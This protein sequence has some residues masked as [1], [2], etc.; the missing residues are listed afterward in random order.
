MS[1]FQVPGIELV[2]VH[3]G[4]EAVLESVPDMPDEGAMVE[5]PG[6]LLEEFV[7]QPDLQV[8]TGTVGVGQQL[9]QDT[10]PPTAGLH[11]LPGGDEQG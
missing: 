11:G 7:A 1:V 8:L 4:A 6:M 5:T 10:G 3:Q 9:G 2:V